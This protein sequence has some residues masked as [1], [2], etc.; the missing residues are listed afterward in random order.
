MRFKELQQES[1]LY[2]LLLENHCYFAT[3]KDDKPF[4]WQIYEIGDEEVIKN[5]IKNFLKSFYQNPQSYFIEL[6]Y[7]YNFNPSLRFAGED[8]EEE[9]LL[10]TKIYAERE[11]AMCHQA[12]EIAIK[13]EN[14]SLSFWKKY[15]SL[16][17]IAAATM[18]IVAGYELYL[19][20]TID[21]YEQKIAHLV[22]EQVSVANRNN[23]YKAE[24]IHFQKLK[25]VVEAIKQKNAFIATKIRTIFDLIP[26][27]A[28]LTKAEIGKNVL[29][30]EGVCKSKHS[31]LQAFHEKMAKSFQKKRIN[32]S[33]IANGYKFQ[34]VYEEMIDEKG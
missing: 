9:L 10:P 1:A 2:C 4:F 17:L 24:V 33:K 3:F 20:Y 25:P 15:R 26:D 34:A 19:R 28:Y 16:L 32:F 6:I 30:F 8:I 7:L 11:D 21:Q 22:Q 27:D 12:S 18:L 5:H 13:V 14:E 23:T 31:L 29:L